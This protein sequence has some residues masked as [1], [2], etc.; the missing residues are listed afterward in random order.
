MK[1]KIIVKS[2]GIMSIMTAFLIALTATVSADKIADAAE[3]AAQ[4]LQA[5]AIGALKPLIVIVL[6]IVGLVFLIGS[7]RAKENQKETAW[8]KILGIAL[9]ICA[10][11]IAGIIFGWFN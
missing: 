4:G 3:G 11:P 6:V 8:E 5:S 1:Q 7:Q 2:M 10:V 9:I